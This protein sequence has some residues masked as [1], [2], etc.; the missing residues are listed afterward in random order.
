VCALRAAG[1]TAEKKCRPGAFHVARGEGVTPAFQKNSRSCTL[2]RRHVGTQVTNDRPQEPEQWFTM[3]ANSRVIYGRRT[4]AGTAAR[5][6]QSIV[7]NLVRCAQLGE[8][9]RLEVERGR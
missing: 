5:K 1:Q 8:R 9:L 2:R 7:R 6:R 3:R 4:S